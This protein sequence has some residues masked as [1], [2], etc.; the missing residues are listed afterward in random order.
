MKQTIKLRESEL[1]RIIS[2]SVRRALNEEH[3]GTYIQGVLQAIEDAI[4]STVDTEIARMA[5]DGNRENMMRQTLAEFVKDTFSDAC[6]LQHKR[7]AIN[8]EIIDTPP[9][10]TFW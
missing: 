7:D 5:I 10:G 3:G 8:S 2:E 1:K 6:G 4:Y 9:A